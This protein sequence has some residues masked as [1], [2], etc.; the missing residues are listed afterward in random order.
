[1]RIIVRRESQETSVE[2][3]LA[4]HKYSENN[5]EKAKKHLKESDELLRKLLRKFRKFDLTQYLLIQL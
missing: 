4:G 2:R 1:M 3:S 5:V